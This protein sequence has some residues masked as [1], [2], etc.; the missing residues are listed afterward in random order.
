M[1]RV[2]VIGA[3]PSG[4]A[5]VKAPLEEGHA[6]TCFERAG[7]LGGVSRFGEPDGAYPP[8]RPGMARQ[9]RPRSR[10]LLRPVTRRT[11]VLLR[12]GVRGC[13]WVATVALLT[14][15]F[16]A[17]ADLPELRVGME[18]RLPPWSFVP[19]LP[20]RP[21]PVLSPA[22]LQELTGLDVDV[23]KALF[24]K[25][26][27]KPVIVPTVWYELEKDLLAGKFDVI[28]SA[29]TP[30]PSMPATIAYSPSYCDWGLVVVMRAADDRVKAV[31]D[32][33]HQNLRVGHI[34][35]PSVKRSLFALGGG[36][37]EVRT[38]VAQLFSDLMV[39]R[40]DAVVY[41]SLYVHW[42]EA[43]QH[44]VRIVGE[45]LNRLGYHLG[46]RQADTALG[47][48]VEAAVRALRDSG[49]LGRIQV[50]WEGR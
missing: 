26:K 1:K 49:E 5:T 28:L 42:R 41:D 10:G 2:A 4:L 9:V 8:G 48:E 7:S 15:R 47:R 20:R 24:A 6:H 16:A 35:D 11:A 13:L 34:D 21:T 31:A 3:G 12:R 14:V 45:P 50:R 43:R 37:F 40:F 38:T 44:D 29:W 17:G 30:S 46:L 18:T 36:S 25:L 23:M 22:E 39:G 19:D 32:L 33:G 27:R